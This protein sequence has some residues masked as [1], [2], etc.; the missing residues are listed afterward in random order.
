M[1]NVIHEPTAAADFIAQTY[2]ANYDL[3]ESV[4][5]RKFRVPEDE[6]GGLIH[7]VFLGFI[8]NRGKVADERAWL[9]AAMCNRCR[10]YW[11]SRGRPDGELLPGEDAEEVPV[12]TGVDVSEQIDVRGV[13]ERL[14][15][16]CRKVI[17]LRFYEEYSSQE[18]ADHFATTVD[19]ARKM[20]YRCVVNARTLFLRRRRRRP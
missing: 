16:R 3:L 19:Y 7:E 2:T 9:V 8:R 17:Q 12:V 6:A 5:T 14:P 20:V 18:I 13:I 4:A 10:T 11:Q 15:E 1:L